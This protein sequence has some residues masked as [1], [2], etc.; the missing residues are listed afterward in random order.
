MPC[1]NRIK[2]NK[3]ILSIKMK[4]IITVI[5][6]LFVVVAC[7]KE[8]IEQPVE[9]SETPVFSVRGKLGEQSVE[10]IAGVDNAYQETLIEVKNEISHFKGTMIDQNE[11]LE[12]SF[13]EGEIGLISDGS[14]L[15]S[16]TIL[17]Q[18]PAENWM[19][20]NQS[21][22]VNNQFVQSINHSVN[23][24]SIGENLIV[25]QPGFNTIC[26]DVSFTDGTTKSIC[27]KYLLGYEDYGGFLINFASTLTST[28]LYAQSTNTPISTVEWFVDGVSFSAESNTSL[29][30]GQ[31]VVIVTAKVVFTNGIKRE[32]SVIVDTD[33]ENRYLKD[34]YLYKTSVETSQLND[35]KLTLNYTKDGVTY[36]SVIDSSQEGGFQVNSVELY[37]EKSN[38]NK[39]YKVSGSINCQLKNLISQELIPLSLEVVYAIEVNY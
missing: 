9:A 14:S 26:T 5:L 17:F 4:K 27:N 24:V 20:L 38:G 7:K 3:E 1:T 36:T 8:V 37:H 23:G 34:L 31:G 12:L 32:H 39:I 10:L 21:G 13:S 6:A 33:G 15:F 18:K 16:G 30:A 22:L 28:N 29:A 25:T 11:R 2:P 19:L 35:Y